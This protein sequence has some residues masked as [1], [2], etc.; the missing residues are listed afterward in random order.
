MKAGFENIRSLARDWCASWLALAVIGQ[1]LPAAANDGAWRVPYELLALSPEQAEEIDKL[2]RDWKRQYDELHPELRRRK[3]KLVLLLADSQCD[4]LVVTELQYEIANLKARLQL[5][6]T[7]N[8]LAKR[9]VLNDR[10]K[11]KLEDMLK[12]LLSE[13]RQPTL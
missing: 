2:E 8:Y 6:A 4:P 10:Q 5:A 12:R 13:R 3:K 11:S 7:A 1:A 9:Q